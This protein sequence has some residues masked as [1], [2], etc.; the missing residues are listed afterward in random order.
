MP[1]RWL[2]PAGHVHLSVRT[3]LCLSDNIIFHQTPILN[4]TCFFHQKL[5]FILLLDLPQQLSSLHH[6]RSAAIKELA[7]FVGKIY[8]EATTELSGGQSRLSPALKIVSS[9]IKGITQY[10]VVFSSYE[11][12]SGTVDPSAISQSLIVTRLRSPILAES[13]SRL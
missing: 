1:V 13:E 9:T 11:A 7:N 5:D 12:L 4:L 2:P 6:Y 3:P 10:I 8:P